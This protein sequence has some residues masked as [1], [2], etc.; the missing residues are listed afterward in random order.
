M[1]RLHPSLL[2]LDKGLN[3]QTAKILAPEGT[4]MDSLNYEQ[5]DFQGQKRIDGYARYDGSCLPAID[6]FVLVEAAYYTTT[7]YGSRT[8]GYNLDGEA[9][10][11]QVG[12]IDTYTAFAV[13]NENAVPA[14]HLLGNEYV[15]DPLIH[16]DYVLQYTE[17]LRD[18]VEYLPGAVIGLHWFRDRLYAVADM[19]I[20]EL[21]GVVDVLP[22]DIMEN[23]DNDQDSLVLSHSEYNGNTL[24]LVDRFTATSTQV[25][26][27][28]T[29]EFEQVV[30]QHAGLQAS[31]FESRTERQVL[32][33][34]TTEFDF[35]WVFKHL[36][37]AVPFEQGSAAYGELT[38][39]NQN[40]QG[41]GVQGPTT[42]EGDNGRPLTLTQKVNI[43]NEQVQVNGWKSSNTPTTYNLDPA[44]IRTLDTLYIYADAFVSWNGTTGAI[45]TATPSSV[46]VE[47]SPTN[48]V[49]VDV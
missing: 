26:F 11:V 37:W 21:D 35:G 23:S 16:Y 45:T 9:F 10:G 30:D 29:G 19:K 41:V 4:V 49:E 7:V 22:N 5:V 25:Y 47:Q 36:G 18:L 48:N 38:S 15:A 39:L 40:R 24:I 2:S 8:I 31:F 44:N 27:P 42:I 17:V 6:D 28:R 34:E 20:L 46:L 32:E 14:E 43:V 1:S 13:I 3:L 12:T 33:E